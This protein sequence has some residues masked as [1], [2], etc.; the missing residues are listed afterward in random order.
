MFAIFAPTLN[1]MMMM[2][3]STVH[4]PP[5][6][7]LEPNKSIPGMP[8]TNHHDLVILL[9]TGLANSTSRVE[10]IKKTWASGLGGSITIMH[11]NERCRRKYGDNHWE[12]LTC[13]EASMHVEIM[14]Q[15]DYTFSW[16]LVVDDDTYVFV[17]RLKK[18]LS[19]LDPGRRA[20]FG[21]PGCGNCG[22]GVQSH[23]EEMLGSGGRS[24]FCG[25]GGYFVSRENLFRMAGLRGRPV[26]PSVAHAF[27]DHFMQDPDR[28]W[29]DVRFAC[30]AQEMGLELVHQPGMRG[31]PIESVRTE[32]RIIRLK[33]DDPPLVFHKVGNA[34]HMN[35]IHE[36]A[37]AVATQS[38]NSSTVFSEP[39]WN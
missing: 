34:S 39:V 20:A 13:L 29:C 11:A 8:A 27:V 35:R 3:S 10:S 9:R 15:T 6:R 21:V 12:G 32:E 19:T 2:P 5:G 7:E 1:Q 28:V 4:S 26:L 38:P 37:V 16:L 30:V 22:G 33:L 17:D 31:N 36:T 23:R 24:G 18:L 14:N 25:G